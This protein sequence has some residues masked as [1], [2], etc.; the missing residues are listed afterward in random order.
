VIREV[1]VEQGLDPRGMALLP[2]GGAGPLLATLMAD[3]L[4]MDRIVVPPLA[5]NFSAWGLLGADMIQP[6]A[7][8]AIMDLNGAGIARANHRLTELFV[9]LRARADRVRRDAEPRAKLDLR[10]QGQEHWLS[11]DA[12]LYGDGSIA[13]TVD[14]IRQSFSDDYQRTFCSLMHQAV[15]IVP[16]RATIRVPLPRR[17]LVQADLAASAG[18]SS[19]YRAYSFERGEWMNF[20]VLDRS[21]IAG[22][23]HGP[24][25][26]VEG[27]SASD[28][29]FNQPGPVPHASAWTY[30]LHNSP[31]RKRSREGVGETDTMD[32]T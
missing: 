3:E 14:A 32:A 5:G 6:A 24:A 11:I 20:Q 21:A 8:T 31:P 29:R 18:G 1:T 12:A 26:I 19:E 16:V 25:I 7:R 9:A 22:E 4:E 15:E 13:E 2:F 28:H 30:M 23:I 27:R 10:Y 17:Q